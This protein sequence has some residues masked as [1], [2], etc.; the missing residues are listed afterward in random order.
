MK[1]III[2]FF[3]VLLLHHQSKAQNSRLTA[4][5]VEWEDFFTTTFVAVNCDVFHR[6][7][8]NTIE[9]INFIKQSDLNKLSTM[10]KGFIAADEKNIDVRGTITFIYGKIKV[11]YCFDQFGLFTDNQKFYYNK[12]L[13]AFIEKKLYPRGFY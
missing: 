3:S 11:K 8:S 10:T 9:T 2:I 13:M 5:K 6:T 7:F 1:R 4:V 12:T